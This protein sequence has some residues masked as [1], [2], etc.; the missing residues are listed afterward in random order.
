[1]KSVNRG[2]ARFD[3]GRDLVIVEFLDICSATRTSGFVDE[4]RERKCHGKFDGRVQ[5]KLTA[6]TSVS[7]FPRTATRG[8]DYSRIAKSAKCPRLHKK[9]KVKAV[10]EASAVNANAASARSARMVVQ[11]IVA[12]ATA[13]RRGDL[14]R[15]V[16]LQRCCV[17]RLGLA[18]CRV[19]C[20][21]TGS[22]QPAAVSHF[23]ASR[24]CRPAFRAHAN[25]CGCIYLM[26]SIFTASKSAIA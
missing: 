8:F 12:T 21:A 2:G 7:S 18:E 9:E 1:M 3:F 26:F 17:P 14:F 5:T 15:M 25:R 13:G 6:P 19:F 10:P 4:E 11:R 16:M 24:Q 20:S 23:S 22:P